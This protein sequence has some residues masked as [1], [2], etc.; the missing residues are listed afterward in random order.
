MVNSKVNWLSVMGRPFKKKHFVE[1]DLSSAS[2]KK[3]K[4]NDDIALRAYI[5][6]KAREH[7]AFWAYGGYLEQRDFYTSAL[8]R[9]EIEPR[10]IHLGIDIWADAHTPIYAPFHGRIH[11][12]AY[13]DQQLDYGY[14]V[15][16]EHDLSDETIYSLYG[17]LS[18]SHY[19]LWRQG[20]PIKEGDLLGHIGPKEENGGWLP[21]LH[22]QLIRDLEGKKGDYPGVCAES[23]KDYYMDNCPKPC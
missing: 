6:N 2:I 10:N 5:Y 9:E 16:L 18:S 14:T 19:Q 20:S 15:I 1:I 3:H 22:L 17:H 11:S 23:R 12:F 7:G 4:L 8:F 21:H 13:N